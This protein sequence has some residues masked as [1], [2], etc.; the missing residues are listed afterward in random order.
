MISVPTHDKYTFDERRD[1]SHREGGT[2]N[3]TL[4]RRNNTSRRSDAASL[5]EAKLNIYELRGVGY[6]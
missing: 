3:F 5:G 2:L 1:A 6:V 4:F